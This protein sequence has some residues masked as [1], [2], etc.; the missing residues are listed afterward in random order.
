MPEREVVLGIE[1]ANGRSSLCL[2]A[3]G[4]VL[5]QAQCERRDAL[6]W[7]RGSVPQLLAQAGLA[8]SELA[9]L[10]VSH[11]PGALTGVRV[12]VAYA[13]GLALAW[14]RPLVGI[15]TLHALAWSAW[16]AAGDAAVPL[17][18]ALDAR[19]GEIYEWHGAALPPANDEPGDRLA[20]PRPPAGIA[21]YAGPGWEAYAEQL[22]A[23]S[24]LLP[25]PAAAGAGRVD[26]GGAGPRGRPERPACG[27]GH[28]L[29][30]RTGGAG[31]PAGQRR[32]RRQARAAE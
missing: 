15:N 9:A 7:L 12:G 22:P 25:E 26:T 28:P 24:T 20:A 14:R 21:L 18:V 17:S 19:M 5:A 30:A 16:Q 2:S 10:A 11:G 1:T 8:G 3:G 13:Q 27:S 31:T 23:Q 4:A 6:G 32:R 29:P